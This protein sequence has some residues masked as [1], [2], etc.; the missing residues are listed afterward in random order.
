MNDDS[1][2]PPA[3]GS[4]APAVPLPPRRPP[5]TPG[6]AAEWEAE[7]QRFLRLRAAWRAGGAR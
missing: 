1:T 3:D 6:Q 5:L 7:V 2:Y 4:T